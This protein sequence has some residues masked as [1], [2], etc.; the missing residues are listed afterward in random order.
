MNDQHQCRR[1]IIHYGCSFSFTKHGERTLHIVSAPAAFAFGKIE[2]QIRIH[3]SEFIQRVHG[4]ARKRSASEI[5]VN[6]NSSSVDDWLKSAGAEFIKRV[7]DISDNRLK[8]H[9]DATSANL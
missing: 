7:T 4:F 9:R 6:D 2:F 3:C 1:A 8:F 5:C